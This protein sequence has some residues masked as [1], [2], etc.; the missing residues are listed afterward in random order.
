[1]SDTLSWVGSHD[2]PNKLFFFSVSI[3]KYNYYILLSLQCVCVCVCR[4]VSY[5][6]NLVEIVLLSLLLYFLL[7][8]AWSSQ[9]S[10][11]KY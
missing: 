9:D 5:I 10:S 11:S 3:T 7:K 6:F 8:K 4:H 2:E 1:M